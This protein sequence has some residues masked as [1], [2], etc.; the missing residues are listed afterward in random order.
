MALQWPLILFTTF[1]A[2]CAGSFSMQAYLA[3][4]GKGEK[5]Q[6]IAWIVSAIL[7][8]LAGGSVFLH[9]Q[10]WERIFNGFG[11]I[12]SGITQEL[13]AI[14]VLAVIAIVYLAF[15]RR[16]EGRAPAWIGVLAIIASV[17]LLVVSGHSYMMQSRPA[18]NNV[19][20]I[21]S[22]LG[23]ACI[24]GPATIA[25]I[26]AFKGES[27]EK[28]GQFMLV[29]GIINAVTS[30]AAALSVFA[31]SSSIAN[32]GWY[33]DLTHPT[34]A[35]MTPDVSPFGGLAMPYMVI[36]VIIIGI[37]GVIAGAMAGKKTGNWKTWAPVVLTCACI[38][39][40]A[41][42]AVFYVSGVSM[43]MFY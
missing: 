9:L 17:V 30:L 32:V 2:W 1:L 12:T 15:I 3:I 35:I 40:I 8:A 18:W 16:E 25:V 5:I 41:L 28:T 19:L 10:H 4:K 6:M 27:V 11:H 38:G 39:T 23:A 37:V 34:K 31:A 29:G 33:F 20:W 36:G 26:A 14:V 22:L 43:F 24:L 13:I 7:L 21:I 42:R